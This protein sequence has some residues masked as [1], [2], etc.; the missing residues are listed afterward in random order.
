MNN[1]V[2]IEEATNEEVAHYNFFIQQL[3]ASLFKKAQISKADQEQV[4][5]KLSEEITGRPFRVAIIGQSGVGKSSTLNA[6]FGLNLPTSDIEEGTTEIIEKIFPMRDGFNLSIYDMPGLLQSRKKDQEYIEMYKEILPKCD[7]IVYII[8]ANTRNIGDD[9][10]ILKDVVLP[11][12]NESSVKDNLIIAVNKVDIIGESFDASDPELVW[13]PIAN[14]PSK[15]LS[16]CIHKK[17]MD[18]FEK[19]ISENLVLINDPKAI[20]P[21]Q[22][23]FYSAVWGYHLRQFLLAITRAGKR[24]F[25]WTSTIGFDLLIDSEK[26]NRLK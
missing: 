22:V 4:F 26:S 11:I 6:V 9:C 19:L 24:G 12:C 16:A 15:K 7:V 2:I 5:G 8:K 18:I 13:D 23:V 25:I 21:D 17:R 1:R 10:R 20:N 14:V 3:L